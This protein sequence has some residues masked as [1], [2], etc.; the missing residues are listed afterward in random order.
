MTVTEATAR[1]KFD[2][3]IETR[4]LDQAISD[5]SLV[6]DSTTEGMMIRVALIYHIENLSPAI[7]AWVDEFYSGP[8]EDPR[9]NIDY[10]D[11]ILL[12]RDATRS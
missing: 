6:D 2:A 12:A 4:T 9:W 11:A 7:K 8:D 10:P 5:L 3:L 1:E